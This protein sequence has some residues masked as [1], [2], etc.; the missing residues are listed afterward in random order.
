MCLRIFR[1]AIE[2]GNADASIDSGL[3]DIKATAVVT[4]DFKHRVPPVKKFAGLAGISHAM[5][6]RQRRKR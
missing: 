4:K 1:T 5:E 6:A 3:T 2:H